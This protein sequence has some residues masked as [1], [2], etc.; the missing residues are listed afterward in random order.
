MFGF[1]PDEQNKEFYEDED[2]YKFSQ[3]VYQ[4]I[5][6]NK[7]EKEPFT[8]FSDKRAIIIIET[9]KIKPFLNNIIE[10]FKSKEEYEICENLMQVMKNWNEK[11][12]PVAKKTKRKPK[13][14]DTQDE[15]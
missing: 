13:S 8:I 5:S 4:Y 2:F 9:T 10:K 14:S 15:Q 12:K 3:K 6:E 1:N 7:Q 11:I